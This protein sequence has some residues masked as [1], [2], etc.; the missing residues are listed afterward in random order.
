MYHFIY[1]GR[2]TERN[3]AVWGYPGKVKRRDVVSGGLFSI[4]LALAVLLVCMAGAVIGCED[5][6][7]AVADKRRRESI[8]SEHSS[9]LDFNIRVLLAGPMEECR[10]RSVSGFRVRDLEGEVVRGVADGMSE[11]RVVFKE[12]GIGFSHDKRLLDVKGFEVLAGEKDEVLG[13]ELKEGGVQR[14]RGFMRLLR[15]PK[16]RG[17][18]INVVDVEQYLQSVVAGELQ[19]GFA[20][21]AFRAQAIVARTYAWYEK[22]TSR[23]EDDWDVYGGQWSQVYA[24]VD[25]EKEVPEAV[26]AAR[27][28]R[29][30]VC[31][32]DSPTGER[33]FKTYFSSTCGGCTQ[34]AAEVKQGEDIPPLSGNIRCRYCR[35]SPAYRWGPV[36][37][38]KEEITQALRERFPRF[39]GMGVIEDMEILEESSCGRPMRM[40]F[41]DGE[42]RGK[43]LG[44]ED[45]RLAVDSGGQR[46]PSSFFT[47]VVE[48][49]KIVFTEGRGFGHG[50]G[51]C[52]YGA[53][54]MAREGASARE[55]LRFYYPGCRIKRA[56]K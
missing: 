55:I 33:I 7:G 3:S 2:R 46:L 48:E 31:T 49:G 9:S 34:A 43:E 18:L 19:R 54:G 28:T 22:E 44:A 21:E 16:G 6:S 37:L 15:G 32:W 4:S 14:Y 51:M 25:R 35:H 39:E 45:F 53:D 5:E 41:I 11:L 26:K 36:R 8:L 13:V 29:G 20:R 12:G 10:L 23:P 47:P 17:W 30:L 56:Y 42:G 52:Q 50:M 38:S 24:G 1:S 27:A 40:R